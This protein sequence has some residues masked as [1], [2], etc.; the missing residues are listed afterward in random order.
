MDE[1]KALLGRMMFSGPA[2]NKKCAVLSGGE[3]ARLAMAKFM[4]T[5]GAL[6]TCTAVWWIHE[7]LR[8]TVGV[9]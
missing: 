4:L 3:K 5:K 7:R 8:Y 6:N 2:M 9:G 1:I